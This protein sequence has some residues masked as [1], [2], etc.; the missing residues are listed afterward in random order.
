MISGAQNPTDN[1]APAGK[2]L[3]LIDGYG[4]LFRAY[5]SLPPLTRAD[6]TP[7]G[8]IYGFTNMLLK[9]RQKIEENNRTNP[10]DHFMAIVLDSG[11][12]SFRNEIYADYKANRPPAP[13]DLLPQFPLVREAVKALRLPVLEKEGFEADDLIAT[14]TRAARAEGAKVTIVSSDKD[15]MQLVGQDVWLYDAMKDKEIREKEVIEKF[16]VPPGKVLDALAL[17]GDSSDNIPGVPGIGPKTAAELLTQFGSLE[18]VLAHCSQIKQQKRRETIECNKEQA[19]L[20]R[21]LAALCDTAPMETPMD[22]LALKEMDYPALLTFLKAQDF[23]ALIARVEKM[24]NLPPGTALPSAKGFGS[25]LSP[26]IP[27]LGTGAVPAPVRR[28]EKLEVKTETLTEKNREA[29]HRAVA[30]SGRVALLIDQGT[31]FIAHSGKQVWMMPPATLAPKQDD[32]FSAARAAPATPCALTS[33]KSVLEDPSI[34]KIGYDIKCILRLALCEGVGMQAVDDVLVLSYV[35]DGTSHAHTIELLAEQHL[36][37]ELDPLDEKNDAADARSAKVSRMTAAL[38]LLYDHLKKRLAEEEMTSVHEM[39][40]RPLIACLARMEHRGIKVDIAELGTI[41]AGLLSRMQA[42]EKTIFAAAGHEFNIGSPKQLGEVLFDEMH[43]EGGKKSKK[44]G[45]YATGVEVLSEL[46]DKG[47]T[48]AADVLEW[49]MLSKLRNTYTET[50]PTEVSAKTGRIHTTFMM[51]VTNTGRLSSQHP[52]LQNIP[53]RTPEGKLV[54]RA[55]IAEKGCRLIS[56]DYSQ[57]ELRILAALADIKPL[58]EAFAHGVDVHA[59]TAAQVFGVPIEKVDPLMRRHAKAINFGIIYGQSAFGLAQSLGIPRG[60]AKA[61]IEAYFREYPG[62]LAFMEETKEF[63]RRHGY[64]KTLFG[65]KCYLPNITSKNPAL[66]Q[67]SERAAINAP[68]QGTAADIIKR[69]MIQLDHTLQSQCPEARLLLQI[70]DEL[71]I[72]TPEA[73]APHAAQLVK[74]VMEQALTLSVPFTAEVHTG[75]NWGEI[76]D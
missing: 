8:A 74:R 12:K 71:L 48:I 51:T 58:K 59:K 11:R 63:A 62:I 53:V 49:R 2:H 76:H 43:I 38:W 56:A 68:L 17:M 20:S 18:N 4:F 65:R 5:H 14:Y 16:G 61:Y 47:F 22:L 50:L 25:T 44:S 31:C 69:A 24:A 54:R 32:L 67:F 9:L 1:A 23:R 36:G 13:E 66:R 33:L 70:H 39:I 30:L 41:S 75:M 15:L 46:A 6:G 26:A 21:R 72:E 19:L 45:T 10:E 40:E 3:F 64:V 29:F 60:E 52:N 28:Y 57:I 55:F 35:L 27:A 73:K 34:L 37:F 42:V 7:V